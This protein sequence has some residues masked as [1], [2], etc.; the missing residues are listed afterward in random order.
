MLLLLYLGKINWP[1]VSK[2]F[3][4]SGGVKRPLDLENISPRQYFSILF[5]YSLIEMIEN[6]SF[7][8]KFSQITFSLFWFSPPK[9]ETEVAPG[10]AEL[11]WCTGFSWYFASVSFASKT[12]NNN[13]NEAA[14]IEILKNLVKCKWE[15][16]LN[17]L[18]L[19]LFVLKSNAK[20]DDSN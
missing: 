19:R 7:K 12:Q 3:S 11:A 6:K 13:R 16:S 4:S 15:K 14:W 8:L 17:H 9:A 20:A 10:R 5:E 18:L 1:L 2:P